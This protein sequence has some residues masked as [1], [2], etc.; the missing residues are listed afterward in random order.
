MLRD[1]DIHASLPPH[2]HP[3]GHEWALDDGH[4]ATVTIAPADGPAD[5]AAIA[6]R[7]TSGP[8]G[9]RS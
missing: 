1:A 6:N 7:E 3:L 9:D 4:E 5:A 2:A 8:G